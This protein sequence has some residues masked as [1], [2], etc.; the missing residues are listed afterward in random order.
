MRLDL[1]GL[2]ILLLMLAATPA[3]ADSKADL[4]R[5]LRDQWVGK[6]ELVRG[7]Y[8]GDHLGFDA[9]GSP[10]QTAPSVPWTASWV[11]IK[12]L[13]VKDKDLE[14]DGERAG[15][16]FYDQKRLL[17][18]T[19]EAR[20]SVH[21][22]IQ[23]A[24]AAS[25][26]GEQVRAALDRVFIQPNEDFSSMVPE[27]W[28]DYLH[29][30]L[31]EKERDQNKRAPELTL[32][33][34]EIAYKVGDNVKAPHAQY[35]PDP[36]YFEPARLTRLQGTT[37]LWVVIDRNGNPSEIQIWRPL[38]FGLDEQAVAAV[39]KWRFLPATKDGQPVSVRIFVE[40]NFRLF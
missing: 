3:R 5:S 37:V 40:V 16:V 39:K 22:Q 38:G 25:E 13:K 12:G 6:N 18:E 36:E 24:L 15:L 27:F 28:Q 30:S 20:R 17:P 19:D 21:V 14:M 8:G 2:V 34:G 7:F 33:S 29:G 9:A 11:H 10:L 26:T 31:K 35:A 23:V 4:E 32:P 1:T